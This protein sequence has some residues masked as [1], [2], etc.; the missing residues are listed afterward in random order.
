MGVAVTR[1]TFQS[2]SVNLPTDTQALVHTPVRFRRPW[3]RSV[4][5]SKMRKHWS[6]AHAMH[7]YVTSVPIAL[8]QYTHHHS[9]ASPPSDIA[10]E[11]G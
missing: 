2:T 11:E 9:P 7:A 5:L 1:E 10:R 3:M 4:K 6:C 8:N